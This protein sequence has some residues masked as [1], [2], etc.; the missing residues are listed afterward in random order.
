MIEFIRPYATDF[1]AWITKFGQG[2]AYYDANG[3]YAR[4]QPNFNAFSFSDN[5]GNGL[6]TP[7][8]PAQRRNSLDHGLTRPCPGGAT[9]PAPDGSSPFTDDGKLRPPTATRQRG[10]PGHEAAGIVI[11]L[12]LVAA[13]LAVIFGLGAGGGDGG[14]DYKVRAIF[15]NA[16]FLIPGEDVKVAG[17]KV[18]V[19]DSLDVTPR[20]A[21]RRWS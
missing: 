4:V 12:L 8:T 10:R 16:S 19:V 6:L 9:Q 3:H 20:T 15:N 21:R 7:V 5:G 2:F 17:A 11:V 13:P 18:G 1:A 14:G